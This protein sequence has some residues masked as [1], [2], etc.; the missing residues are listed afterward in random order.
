MSNRHRASLLG[1]RTWAETSLRKEAVPLLLSLMCFLKR[2]CLSCFKNE[3]KSHPSRRPSERH[4]LD[5]GCT[6]LGDECTQIKVYYLLLLCCWAMSY[7]AW[8]LVENTTQKHYSTLAMETTACCEVLKIRFFIQQMFTEEQ[9]CD[10]HKARLLGYISVQKGWRS[11]PCLSE[12][13]VF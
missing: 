8:G 11:P 9:L 7:L 4:Q 1:I 13:T 3:H 6:F 10:K 2:N 5:L 12:Y